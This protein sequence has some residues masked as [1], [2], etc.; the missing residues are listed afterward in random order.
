MPRE[1]KLPAGQSITSVGALLLTGGAL[2]VQ[3]PSMIQL[4]RSLGE[5]IPKASSQVFSGATISLR[6]ECL[7]YLVKTENRHIRLQ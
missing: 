6:H 5:L 7:R 1:G 2:Y 3:L 4:T